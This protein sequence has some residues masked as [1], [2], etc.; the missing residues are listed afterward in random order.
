MRPAPAGDDLV[1]G[2][3][4]VQTDSSQSHIMKVNKLKIR[5]KL[6]AVED[7]VK[8]PPFDLPR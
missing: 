5:L 2:R 4:R 1:R 7:H 8:S 6:T 3:R